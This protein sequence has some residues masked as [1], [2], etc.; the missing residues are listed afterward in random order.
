V[1]RVLVEDPVVQLGVRT[2]ER[3]AGALTDRIDRAYGK[4][5]A[6]QLAREFGHAPPRDAVA[7]GQGHD[8]R[9]QARAKR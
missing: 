4:T 5:Q 3:V 7:S 8:R 2:G 1:E 6:E 9:L